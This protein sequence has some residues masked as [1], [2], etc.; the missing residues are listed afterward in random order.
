M[1]IQALAKLWN[2]TQLHPDTSGGGAAAAVLLGLYNGR[3]FP[4]DM[5][6]LRRL[7]G[8]NLT[9]AMDVIESDVR[10]RFK[11]VHEWLND[12]TGRD[13]F[14]MRLEHLAYEYEFKGRRKKSQLQPLNPRRVVI[15]QPTVPG[16]RQS[17]A[18]LASVLRSAPPIN[19]LATPAK[20]Q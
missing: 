3:R 1:N 13:D 5:T 9:A 6:E 12:I 18:R 2:V 11:E 7:D 4:L 20:E 19:G 8:G 10:F 17:A 16:A 15:N 14:G